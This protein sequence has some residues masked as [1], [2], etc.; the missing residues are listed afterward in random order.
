MWVRMMTVVDKMVNEG[1][2]ACPKRSSETGSCWCAVEAFSQVGD[3]EHDGGLEIPGA[4]L[5]L[6]EPFESGSKEMAR[7]GGHM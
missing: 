3:E 4:S 5:V 6:I 2:W 7:G 1:C